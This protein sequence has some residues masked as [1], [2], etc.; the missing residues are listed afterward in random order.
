MDNSTALTPAASHAHATALS[1][2]VS[3]AAQ[4]IF[5]FMDLPAELRVQVYEALLVVGK[6]FYRTNW[7]ETEQDA[8]LEDMER[9][10]KPG[11]GLFRVSK[12]IQREAEDVY[13]TK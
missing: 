10:R 5:R 8:H 6:V 3:A 1:A 13:L 12:E 2:P 11:L 4:G 9:Y 7:Y